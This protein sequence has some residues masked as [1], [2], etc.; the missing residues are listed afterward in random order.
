MFCFPSWLQCTPIYRI[1]FVKEK[2]LIFGNLKNHE[3]LRVSFLI[4]ICVSHSYRRSVFQQ[5]SEFDSTR[6]TFYTNLPLIN[7]RKKYLVMFSIIHLMWDHHTEPVNITMHMQK[8]FNT[9]Y[10]CLEITCD[11]PTGITGLGVI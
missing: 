4:L 2:H 5:L 9:G 10:K 7:K 8:Y 3:L 11:N 6:S 1:E